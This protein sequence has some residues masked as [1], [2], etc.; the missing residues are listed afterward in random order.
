MN[1]NAENTKNREMNDDR[2]KY[3]E[4]FGI[5]GP[6]IHE[7]CREPSM[8]NPQQSQ[9][10]QIEHTVRPGYYRSRIPDFCPLKGEVG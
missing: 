4:L 1:L 6:G 2:A 5:H 7:N 10:Q 8:G 3:V 9:V